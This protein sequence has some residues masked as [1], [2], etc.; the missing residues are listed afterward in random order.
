MFL[1][2][3]CN[4]S[5]HTT[6][7]RMIT[8][9]GSILEHRGSPATEPDSSQR[10]HNLGAEATSQLH[11]HSGGALGYGE[12]HPAQLSARVRDIHH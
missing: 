4:A 1:L 8:C 6:N 12:L 7:Y 3:V 5:S 9:P 11:I 2:V 10:Y